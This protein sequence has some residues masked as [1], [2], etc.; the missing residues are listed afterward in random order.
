M[1]LGLAGPCQAWVNVGGYGQ[2]G[3]CRL[4]WLE[5]AWAVG[6]LVGLSGS[7][8]AWVG[9]SVLWPRLALIGNRLV[10]ACL[11][12]CEKKGRA[13]WAAQW[14]WLCGP[15][16]GRLGSLGGLQ[17]IWMGFVGLGGFSFFL[18]KAFIDFWEPKH[19]KSWPWRPTCRLSRRISNFM[20]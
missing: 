11:G 7:R 15:G 1:G 9:L 16:M 19:R 20:E 13:S 6:G 8:L 10:W 12:M 4:G 5:L 3:L 17:W 2:V 14:V 18:S